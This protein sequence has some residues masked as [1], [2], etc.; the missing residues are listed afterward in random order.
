MRKNKKSNSLSRFVVLDLSVEMISMLRPVVA[1]VGQRDKGLADQ[2]R[3]AGSSVALNLGESRRRRGGD[4]GHLIRVAS[5]SANEVQVALH[6]AAA[7]GYIDIDAQLLD[8]LDHIISI[9]WK[10]TE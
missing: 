2:I 7:W 3:R 1:K 4:R 9:C 5:G 8:R 6:V 10:L